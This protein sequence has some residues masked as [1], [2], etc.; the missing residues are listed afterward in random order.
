MLIDCSA[1]SFGEECMESCRCADDTTCDAVSGECPGKC[2]DGWTG[3]ACTQAVKG[4][5]LA[6]TPITLFKK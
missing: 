6:N 1:G 4:N 2:A 5:L 3:L